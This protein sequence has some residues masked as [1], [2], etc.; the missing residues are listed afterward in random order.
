MI[1]VVLAAG[2]VGLDLQLSFGPIPSGLVPL[3]GRPVIL[4]VIHALRANGCKRIIVG[5]HPDDFR[6]PELLRRL[7]FPG[8][9]IKTVPVASTGPAQTLLACLREEISADCIVSF[10][11]SVVSFQMTHW[12]RST[13]AV[14][15]ADR[16][17]EGTFWTRA[18]IDETRRVTAIT[19]QSVHVNDLVVTGPYLLSKQTITSLQT[20]S[21]H[22]S[23]LGA[24]FTEILLRNGTPL[25][26]I[27]ATDWIDVGH[28]DEMFR[29]RSRTLAAREFNSIEIN[30]ASG[31]LTKR[32]R[33]L[34]RIESASKWQLRLPAHLAIYFPRIIEH[35]V[36]SEHHAYVTMEFYPYP[37][38][39]ELWAFSC[40]SAGSLWRLT[41]RCLEVHALFSEHKG[42]LRQ[43]SAKRIYWDKTLIRLNDPRVGV[44]ET[45]INAPS[46]LIN[47]QKMPGPR[48]LL[49]LLAS[50]I[51]ALA[52][53]APM[54][55]GLGHGD[56]YFGNVLADPL[57]GIVRLVDPRGEWDGSPI[58]DTRY[59]L[60]KLSHSVHGGFDLVSAGMFSLSMRPGI[61]IDYRLLWQP[62]H[63]QVQNLF[64]AYI[65][66]KGI[67]LSDLRLIEGLL[68][69]SMIPLH[70]DDESRQ[71]CFLGRA[72]EIL[73]P[74]SLS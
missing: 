15:L 21:S 66:A 33:D 24:L 72:M 53:E 60:A 57:T 30:L 58:M 68:F 19:E 13:D 31:L 69:L 46:L 40:A 22:P 56:L 41:K 4:G 61:S 14:V 20:S 1:G 32:S 47:G 27:C 65:E 17:V 48:K 54:F 62:E 10:A 63:T 34:Q 49:N 59:D 70:S 18:T 16:S 51:E 37:S 5:F 28:S 9:T 7:H 43:G 36:D 35:G 2:T 25:H 50:R 39:A 26:A 64:D 67:R 23:G 52:A 55:A 73:F 8:T 42:V 29:S 38:L 3:R 11:D 6:T 12:N 71:L 74:L 44:S 45:F